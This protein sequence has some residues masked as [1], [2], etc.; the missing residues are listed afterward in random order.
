MHN[1]AATK[2]TRLAGQTVWCWYDLLILVANGL[3]VTV[4]LYSLGSRSSCFKVC[5]RLPSGWLTKDHV[6]IESR[7]LPQSPESLV[8]KYFRQHVAVDCS[9]AWP[10]DLLS[11]SAI[12]ERRLDLRRWKALSRLLCSFKGLFR[13]QIC[14]GRHVRPLWPKLVHAGFMTLFDVQMPFRIYNA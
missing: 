1:E 4:Y 2:Q 11:R 14:L 5:P 12:S 9:F 13:L 8:G 10:E 7:S 6:L 3:A